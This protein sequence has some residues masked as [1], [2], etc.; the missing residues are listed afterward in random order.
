MPEVIELPLVTLAVFT[1]GKWKPLLKRRAKTNSPE[2][3]AFT[4]NELA[5]ELRLSK[6]YPHQTKRCNIVDDSGEEPV[7]LETEFI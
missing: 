4:I 1:K 3:V 7:L 5:E 6:A 2:H